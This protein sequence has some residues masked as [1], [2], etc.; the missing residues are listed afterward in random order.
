MA[1]RPQF[2]PLAS[3]AYA[4]FRAELG[5]QVERIRALCFCDGALS[6]ADVTTLGRICHTLKGGAGFFGLTEIAE[7][8]G[9][10][11]VL[12]INGGGS[13]HQQISSAVQSLVLLS[14]NLPEP[15]GGVDRCRTS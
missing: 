5:D 14:Q 1:D 2:D 12:Y 13:D 15:T 10:L 7:V 9:R 4:L 6:A 11:E 3:R 8:A